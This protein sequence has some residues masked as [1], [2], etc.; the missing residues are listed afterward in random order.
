MH[1]LLKKALFFVI[2]IGKKNAIKHM[3]NIYLKELTERLVADYG[4]PFTRD[5]N[6]VRSIANSCYHKLNKT[7]ANS[8]LMKECVT[9]PLHT[10]DELV[11]SNMNGLS[12]CI[13][14]INDLYLDLKSNKVSG[15]S[16]PQRKI[17]MKHTQYIG[18]LAT[19]KRHDYH[20]SYID[21]ANLTQTNLTKT[22]TKVININTLYEL[23]REQ[24][25][26]LERY[27]NQHFKVIMVS[28]TEV[29]LRILQLDYEH[30]YDQLIASPPINN[31]YFFKSKYIIFNAHH[32][33]FISFLEQLF[34]EYNDYDN[35]YPNH[36]MQIQ[37]M[38]NI[39]VKQLN[40][41]QQHIL[42]DHDIDHLQN[43]LLHCWQQKAIRPTSHYLPQYSAMEYFFEVIKQTYQEEHKQTPVDIDDISAFNLGLFNFVK[44]LHCVSDDQQTKLSELLSHWFNYLQRHGY[45]MSIVKSFFV[46]FSDPNNKCSYTSF[47]LNTC[48]FF[49]NILSS[50]PLEPNAQGPYFLT[51]NNTPKRHPKHNNRPHNTEDSIPTN[52]DKTQSPSAFSTAKRRLHF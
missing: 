35:K 16:N 37:L 4:N 49:L 21:H 44:K 17:L 10:N 7:P 18:Y 24:H 29:M 8:S 11:L 43:K 30:F 42:L 2:I 36:H 20:E 1:F 15:I 48:S 27:H 50:Y 38:A 26:D 14:W 47:P 22:S 39:I 19:L 52:R 46:F 23:S 5:G 51:A 3:K 31:H 12:S 13:Q 32:Q 25:E 34:D 33:S 45:P 40:Q 28:I 41:T 9:L 6:Q